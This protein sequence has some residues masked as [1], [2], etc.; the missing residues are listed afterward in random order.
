MARNCNPDYH[1][2]MVC[3]ERYPGISAC[4]RFGGIQICLRDIEVPVKR[5]WI[6]AATDD[7]NR[8]LSHPKQVEP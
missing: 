8:L 2:G 5:D 3:R 4:T 1:G 7:D 6:F